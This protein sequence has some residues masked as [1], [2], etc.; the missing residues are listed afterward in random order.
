MN[1]H[2]SKILVLLL[3]ALT[4]YQ[5][6]FAD[7]KSFTAKP[8]RVGD[9]LI[10]ILRHNGFSQRDR[11]K[12]LA[13]DK[14]LRN[15]F[16]TLDTKYL[17]KKSGTTTELRMFD[18]QT[19][20]SYQITKNENNVSAKEYQPTYNVEIVRVDGKVYGSL[21]GSIQSKVKSNWV[22]TRFMDAYAFDLSSFRS[23]ARG[24]KFWFTVEKLYEAGD[25][26]LITNSFC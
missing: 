7:A 4:S 17:V 5:P 23:V 2:L 20:A 16:L 25:S 12:V 26:V 21:L 19:S 11:E 15:L 1:L 18:S 8:V 13:S 6:A 10:S 9:N 22:A 24:A 3:V 14:G